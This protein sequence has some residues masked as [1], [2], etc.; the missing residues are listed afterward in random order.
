MRLDPSCM[1]IVPFYRM[2]QRALSCLLP[3]EETAR[4]KMVVC[5]PERQ[6][7]PETKPA[8]VL[9]LDF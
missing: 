2:P 4:K 1:G 5:E 3:S 6:F 8:C 9:I 7:S